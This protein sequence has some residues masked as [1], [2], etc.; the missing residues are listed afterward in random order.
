MKRITR[1]GGDVV[2]MN[3]QELV[4]AV[5]LVGVAGIFGGITIKVMADLGLTGDGAFFI[6]N[7]TTGLLNLASQ[8]SLIGT[9]IGLAIV[10]TVLVGAFAMFMGGGR[11]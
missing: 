11:R 1:F 10:L 7:A 5:G 4:P 9:V 8:F 3:L 2:R 6:G